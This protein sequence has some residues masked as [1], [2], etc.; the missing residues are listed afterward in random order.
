MMD[1]PLAKNLKELYKRR[2]WLEERIE[3]DEILKK[4]FEE[5]E[6]KK[7]EEMTKDIANTGFSI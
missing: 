6:N 7:L 5:L 4:A 1:E 3:S 2:P